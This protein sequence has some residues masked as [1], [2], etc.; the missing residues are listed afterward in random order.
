MIN[1]YISDLFFNYEPIMVAE[2][3]TQTIQAT[4]D[5]IDTIKGA[6]GVELD[7]CELLDDYNSRL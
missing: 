6:F 7:F 3:R 1:T 4:K 5:F 2:T